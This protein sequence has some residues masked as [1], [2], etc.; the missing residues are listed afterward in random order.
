MSTAPTSSRS[1]DGAESRPQKR[2]FCN[3]ID[4][5]E[6]FSVKFQLDAVNFYQLR[7]E[8]DPSTTTEDQIADEL[9]ISPRNLS[10][11]IKNK[12]SLERTLKLERQKRIPLQEDGCHIN[13]THFTKQFISNAIAYYTQA[14]EKNETLTVATVASELQVRSD[15][16]SQWIEAQNRAT[17]EKDSERTPTMVQKKPAQIILPRAPIPSSNSHFLP[18]SIMLSDTALTNEGCSS[19]SFRQVVK[20]NT[21]TETRQH[22]SSPAHLNRLREHPKHRVVSA[23]IVGDAAVRNTHPSS[24]QPYR[25]PSQRFSVRHKLEMLKAYHKEQTANPGIS[26]KVIAEKLNVLPVTLRYW[27]QQQKALEK[28]ENKDQI[29]THKVVRRGQINHSREFKLRAIQHYFRLKAQNPKVTMNS[30]AQE[31]NVPQNTFCRWIQYKDQIEN[32]PTVSR[33]E[34]RSNVSTKIYTNQI[35]A[36]GVNYYLEQKRKIPG[37]PVKVVAADLQVPPK[38]LGQWITDHRKVL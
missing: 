9:H 1:F 4:E 21:R 3:L 25:K 8:M 16:F 22:S 17:Q 34:V 5:E 26:F 31:Y 36:A 28:V 12:A 2:K 14:K 11:W 19:K 33:P 37:L 29:T 7:K 38:M 15:I 24:S 10:I 27:V 30:V 23:A 13:Q 32:P 6:E 35:K 20:P 18:A